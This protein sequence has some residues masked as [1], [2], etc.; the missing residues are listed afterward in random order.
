M[1]RRQRT[2]PQ[3][4]AKTT[5]FGGA[6]RCS[7]QAPQKHVLCATHARRLREGKE[8]VA[9]GSN[10]P[11][12][13]QGSQAEGAIGA[14]ESLPLS[15]ARSGGPLEPVTHAYLDGVNAKGV[16]GS[17]FH[18]ATI[19]GLPLDGGPNARGHWS[20]RAKKVAHER[21]T[22]A[23]VLSPKKDELRQMV[24][25]QSLTGGRVR[26]VLVRV[27]RKVDSDNLQGRCKAVRDE[28]AAVLGVDDGDERVVK[29]EY[30]QERGPSALKIEFWEE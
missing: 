22:V 18:A 16:A 11:I 7:K 5:S 8:V 20:L 10:K 17:L 13:I 23:W 19:G 9:W 6:S 21:H 24:A 29:Y 27:G 15:P 14:R 25:T 12:L 4:L 30:Q 2:G 1:S 26:V 28:V 3:C